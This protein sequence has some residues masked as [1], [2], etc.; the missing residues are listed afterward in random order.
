MYLDSN[1]IP[2]T[3]VNS[4]K[5]AVSV[6]H[7]DKYAFN[8]YVRALPSIESIGKI[9]LINSTN[10]YHTEG[11]IF[12]QTYNAA[13]MKVN[14]IAMRTNGHACASLL[15]CTLDIANRIASTGGKF[16]YKLI[17]GGSIRLDTSY[18]IQGDPGEWIKEQTDTG[19][20]LKWEH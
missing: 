10:R 14:T 12:Y 18:Y 1:D 5:G 2:V 11:Q 4:D 3:P 15:E 7:S 8:Y 19:H 13:G 6:Y 9:R 16:V 20:E 17:P